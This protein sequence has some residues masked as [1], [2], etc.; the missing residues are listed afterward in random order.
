MQKA[1]G[2]LLTQYGVAVLVSLLAL[3]LRFLLAPLLRENAPLLVFIMPVMFSAWYGGLKPGLLATALSALVGCYFFVQPSFSLTIVEI[4]NVVR[5]GIFLV[6]GVLISWLNEALRSSRQRTEAIALSLKES[7]EQY[8]L[9]VEGVEDYAIFM[10][11]PNGRITT[12][13]NGAER[14]KGYSAA[15]ILGRHYSILF[16]PE[17]IERH[18]PE[19]ELQIAVTEGHFVGEGW[20]RRKDGSLFWATAVLTALRDELGNLRGFSKVTRDIT[21]RKQ[22]EEDLRQLV[23][24]LL[25]VKFALDQAAILVVTD[26][27]GV[28]TNVN[29]KFCQISQ[30]SREELIGQTHRIVNSGYHPKEFFQNLWSTITKGQVWHGE[31]Q[32]RAKDGTHYWM[33]TTIVPFLDD[34]GKPVQYLAIR[35]DITERKRAEEAIRRSAERLEALHEIDRAILNAQSSA[36]LTYTALSRLRRLVPYEQAVLVLFKFETGEAETLVG[37]ANG[38]IAIATVPMSDLMSVEVPLRYEPIRYVEDLITFEQSPPLLERQ[39]AEGKRSFLSVS[40]TMEGELIGQLD[41]FAT[42]VAA[43]TAEHK[44]IALEVANQ[45][46]IALQQA[47]LREQLQG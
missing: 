40:L 45:L 43:F 9:L 23:K 14:I 37:M 30:Y 15:E 44:E 25:D 19:R 29:D 33:D 39:L 8:R 42:P 20:R 6:E 35:F 2:L 26:A 12:W 32:N 13:N 24:E 18:E 5:V 36:H 41:L 27:R 16:T 47:R 7:E 1:K 10:L 38:E 3:L 31:I 21:L 4:G 28:I 34:Q 22:A 11:D 17:D 46:A